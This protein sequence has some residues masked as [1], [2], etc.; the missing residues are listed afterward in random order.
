[1]AIMKEALI[2]WLSA[3]TAIASAHRSI[4]DEGIGYVFLQRF[5]LT[6]GLFYHTE[7]LVCNRNEFSADDQAML[8]K[9]V[10]SMT[11]FSEMD[12][13]WWAARTATC[14]EMGYG[15]AACSEECCG[16]PHGPTQIFYE[17]ISRTAVISII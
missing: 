14:V 15:G 17:I 1:M 3:F 5:P 7:V 2:I 13:T 10:A 11:D 12:D 4:H 6:G 9:T 8:D 16:V